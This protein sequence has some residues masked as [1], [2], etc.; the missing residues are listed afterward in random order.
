MQNK[1]VDEYF[2]YFPQLPN[3]GDSKKTSEKNIEPYILT[4]LYNLFNSLLLS[5]FHILYF[6]KYKFKRLLRPINISILNIF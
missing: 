4:S 3:P 6:K 5:V 1:T 2:K